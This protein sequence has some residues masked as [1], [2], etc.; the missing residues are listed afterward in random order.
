MFSGFG[1]NMF[2]GEAFAPMNMKFED[3]FRVYPV[4]MMPDLIRKDDSNYGGKIF[5]P[6]SALNRLTM[7]HI[8]YP[9]LFELLNE[10]NQTKTYSGV[11]EFVAEE[12][13]VYVPQWMMNTLEVQPGQLIQVSSCDLP[14]GTYVKI[15]PQSVD[16][17]DI[18]DPKAVLE[19]ALRNFSTLTV[20]DVIE[21]NYND[22]IYGIKVLSTK[23][24]N[25]YQGICIVETDLQTEFAPPVGY[26]EPEY[27]PQSQVSSTNPITPSTVNQGAGAATMAKSL[28]YAKL[29]TLSQ[30]SGFKGSGQKL[31]GKT[32]DTQKSF[33]VEDLDLN[34]PAAPFPVPENQ[35]FFGFPVVL[36]TP[37]E[38]GQEVE[39]TDAFSGQ[40]QS[41]R[42]KKRKDKNP[43]Y[44]S[45]K[46]YSR[47][48]ENIELD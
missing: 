48:P 22:T 15:E 1:S 42:T 33:N 9:M 14:L 2:S 5:L 41:L 36:P 19:N 37:E 17:L 47:S 28:E 12:G 45:L 16:F 38:I 43:N 6:Q 32:V 21:I 4:A 35:L 30:S 20:N 7:L 25:I 29:A 3:Y 27:K 34:L 46:N 39:S 11:L 24:D 31:S 26:V 18:S 44:P 13:R 8:R 40:G 23:P 10:N